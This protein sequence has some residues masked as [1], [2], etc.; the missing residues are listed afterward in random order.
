MKEQVWTTE[1]I[2]KEMMQ[3]VAPLPTQAAYTRNLAAIISM[4]IHKNRLIDDGISPDEL[5]APSA[6]VVAPTGQGKTYLI[7]KMAE[8]VGLNV[9]IID[10]GTLAAE[11]WKGISLSQRLA[12]A[13]KE[14]PPEVFAK[15][16]LFLDEVD[17]L[18]FWGTKNDQGNAMTS[19]LQLYNNGTVAVE[20]GKETKHINTSRFTILLGGAFAGL[21]NIVKERVCP[22]QR[23]GFDTDTSKQLSN[24]EL[25]KQVTHGDLAK[26]GMMPELLGRIGT[27][28]TLPPLEIED[29]RQLLNAES[30]SLRRKYHNYL[31]KLYGVTFEIADTGVEKIAQQ[32]MKSET[33]ARAVNPIVN[34]MM[35]SA[36]DAVES[37]FT[38]C[39]VILDADEDGCC[40]HYEH[41]PREYSFYDSPRDK[42]YH[43]ETVREADVTGLSR[44]LYR[45]Y[46]L[47][48]A[49]IIARPQV[50]NF[51]DCA[52]TFLFASCRPA[53]RTFASLEKLAR[54]THRF[55][56]KSSFD[57][58]MEDA[59][60]AKVVTKEQ[61]QKFNNAYTP[62]M[63][64]NLV[65]ALQ[66]IMTA[67]R[68]ELGPCQ[69]KFDV[70]KLP[71]QPA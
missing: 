70:L 22:R 40:V 65:E 30:G 56:P 21:E 28:L 39:K 25:M 53:E 16:I 4:H 17:K 33:G 6:I 55:N 45:Y 26:F 69:V 18:K 5:P 7:R 12:A 60:E 51:L 36:V 59:L 38:I 10:C 1:R 43:W 57:V 20:I 63:Q 62:Q 67:I 32:C 23:I 15:S 68:A 48:S 42:D 34:D 24:A 47:S 13:S 49:S 66:I 29:Y 58:I 54:A 50:K 64:Q 37:D 3:H 11:G 71:E 31:S 44:K 27:I 2:Y 52:L 35:R 14:V 61:I 41:G 8:Y 46:R 9:I 19:L